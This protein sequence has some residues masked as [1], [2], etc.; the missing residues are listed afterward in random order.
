MSTLRL[1]MGRALS[2]LSLRTRIAGF[3]GVTVGLVV[4]LVSGAA[5]LT[6]NHQLRLE[7]DHG[8]V[9][10]AEAALTSPLSDPAQ[11]VLVPAAALGAADLRIALL[12]ADGS[13]ITA[14]HPIAPPPM[15]APELAV[16]SGASPLSLRTATI[17]S[18][19][20][21]VV[22][23]PVRPGL[24]L[25][26]ARSLVETDQV[27]GH[28]GLVLFLVGAAGIVLAAIS[29]LAA[30]RAGL[31]PVERLTSAVEHVARTEDLTPIP[32]DGQDELARLATAFNA[33]L[34]ALASSRQ[35]QRDLVA[36]AGHELR[37]PLTSLRTN[38]DLL[39]QSLRPG[40]ASLSDQDR[41]E[42]LA[43]V[44]AQVEELSGLVVDLVELARE[45]PPGDDVEPVDLAVVAERAIERV[46]RRA[47]GLRLAV[48]LEPWAVRG[49]PTLLERVVTN[50]LDN[51]AK[52]SPPGGTV[53]LTL[54][55][56]V[57]CVVDEG[58]GI[59]ESDLPRVFDRF[60][61]SAEA[62]GK[63]GSGLGLAIVHQAVTRH[64]GTVEASRSG[65]GGAVL[66]VRLPGSRTGAAEDP[67]PPAISL[68]TLGAR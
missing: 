16:A 5:F 43:D 22:A 35:R 63:A 28:L 18:V 44:R 67:A 36:D 14:K 33:M 29:G 12:S 65:G 17:G 21:R 1:A 38:L 15:G 9:T 30:A 57:L 26:M 11:L 45:D 41:D 48:R 6:V 13:A 49:D 8:L 23:V 37:T 53:T 27:L 54:D 61:R 64:G 56:G 55:G 68:P 42:L 19:P 3:V 62:R 2:L 51:A 34:G 50:L 20:Y 25:V 40:S 66:T 7:M 58:P 31:R 4:A 46:R 52:W 47:P 59:A 60:Y 39:A 10:R 32:S 24:A